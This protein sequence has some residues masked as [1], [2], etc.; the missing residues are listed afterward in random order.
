MGLPSPKFTEA[1]LTPVLEP[2]GV[3]PRDPVF[4]PSGVRPLTPVLEPSGVRSLTPV[5]EPSI[6]RSLTPV[7]EPSGVR[8]LRPVLDPSGVTHP[9]S[10]SGQ[11]RVGGLHVVA[12]QETLHRKLND[13]ASGHPEMK[14]ECSVMPNN[15]NPNTARPVIVLP[16]KCSISPCE[17]DEPT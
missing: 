11:L 17:R 5:L 3:T 16:L 12:T 9:T 15:Y 6:V 2:S 4:K 7:L 1:P 8:S 13:W 14:V 10:N